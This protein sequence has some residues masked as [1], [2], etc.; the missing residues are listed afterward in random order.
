MR[1]NIATVF[2]YIVLECAIAQ[3]GNAHSQSFSNKIEP[4][5]DGSK[6]L[7]KYT[8]EV[9][10]L[11]TE[12]ASDHLGYTIGDGLNR[13]FCAINGAFPGPNIVVWKGST[14]KITVKNFLLE[15]T[16]F[17]WHG[18]EMKNQFWFNG[19][20][21]LNQVPI[22]PNKEF[23]YVIKADDPPGTYWYHSQ[24]GA[25]RG[26][27]CY[28]AFIIFDPEENHDY[29]DRVL[30][31]SDW[32]DMPNG[33][34][35][36]PINRARFRGPN[37]ELVSDVAFRSYLI[38]GKGFKYNYGENPMDVSNRN[39]ERREQIYVGCGV[40][41]RVKI[42][43][44]HAGLF[45]PFL[46]QVSGFRL[47]LS[48][49]DG[50]D[51]ESLLVDIPYVYPGETYD[52]FLSKRAQV[53]SQQ[54]RDF[55]VAVSAATFFYDNGTVVP[56]KEYGAYQGAADL[57]FREEESGGTEKFLKLEV[58]GDD[59][60]KT[61]ACVFLNCASPQFPPTIPQDTATVYNWTSVCRNV[62]Q[63]QRGDSSGESYQACPSDFDEEIF[64]NVGSLEEKDY[65]AVEG[66]RY[67]QCKSPPY[68]AILNNGKVKD[69]CD[70]CGEECASPDEISIR[71]DTCSSRLC[72]CFRPLELD[73]GKTYQLVLYNEAWWGGQISRN[74][75]IGIAKSIHLH[76]THFYVIDIGYPSYDP[77]TKFVGNIQDKIKSQCVSPFY[78]IN[79]KWTDEPSYA[80][81]DPVL[82]HTVSVPFG[83]FVKIRFTVRNPGWFL[84]QSQ[85]IRHE[86]GG[87]ALPLKFGTDA[88]ISENVRK[89][90]PKDYQSSFDGNC[91]IN[92]GSEEN[93]GS[94]EVTIWPITPKPITTPKPT[95]PGPRRNCNDRLE[96]V[97]ARYCAI[98]GYPSFHPVGDCTSLYITC[99]IQ[100]QG[101]YLFCDEGYRFDRKTSTCQPKHSVHEC[102]KKTSKK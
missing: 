93:D 89:Y 86:L 79:G 33:E 77:V 28:G 7:F 51:V 100:G 14:V 84:L 82:K 63:L 96:S 39:T 66:L 59:I 20:P 68:E 60:C 73:L 98:V 25:Q 3:L 27:G 67:K 85:N 38:N 71:L 6:R 19:I 32:Y 16:S 12:D 29:E 55:K 11:Y 46:F 1:S 74:A 83:G 90:R 64:L 56:A 61:E 50:R 43:I 34:F 22:P 13:K 75:G 8:F 81:D 65:F 15:P 80:N 97:L 58:W 10:S 88:Q 102:K 92:P 37:M 94:N 62:H 57:H 49:S 91:P 48:A 52:F 18:L 4:P 47:E 9:R 95:L 42:R 21:N 53:S 35:D 40:D 41:D 76:G 45:W 70:V 72:T 23:T 36:T 17:H 54:Y 24:Y 31:V 30:L 101:A 5:S 26:D 44:I 78:P 2:T 99:L 87:L 69:V